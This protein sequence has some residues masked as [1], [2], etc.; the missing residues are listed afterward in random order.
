VKAP[1]SIELSGTS[2]NGPYSGGGFAS[3][4]FAADEKWNDTQSKGEFSLLTW[5]YNYRDVGEYQRELTQYQNSTGGSC[6]L[7]APTAVRPHLSGSLGSATSAFTCTTDCLPFSNCAPSVIAISPNAESFANGKTYAFP[8]FTADERYG[9]LWQAQIKQHMTD[10][11]WQPPHKPCVGSPL[12]NIAWRQDDGTCLADISE[13]DT[14]VEMRYYALRPF[15]ESRCELPADAPLPPQGVYIG[16]LTFNQLNQTSSP[17]GNICLPPSI[18][19]HEIGSKYPRT[20]AQPWAIYL[21]ELACVCAEGRFTGEY[22]ANGVSC[23]SV[24]PP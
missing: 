9:A 6:F 12:Q 20:V 7:T 4:L 10:P 5:S 15:V 11:L 2:G 23:E 1:N 18:V 14:G 13:S 22:K 24:P 16:C 17:S 21:R 8:V 3:T 19:G